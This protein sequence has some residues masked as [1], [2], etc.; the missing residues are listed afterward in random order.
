M[1]IRLGERA[2]YK[3]SKAKKEDWKKGGHMSV[4]VCTHSG[5]NA[6]TFLSSVPNHCS[7]DVQEPQKPKIPNIINGRQTKK[8]TRI[9]M[10]PKKRKKLGR[11]R[12]TRSAN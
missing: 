4:V 3:K 5:N 9:Q 7:S 12:F 1:N 2:D 11:H 10:N 6:V 8:C